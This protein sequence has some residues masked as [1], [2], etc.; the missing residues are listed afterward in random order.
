MTTEP[1]I[2]AEITEKATRAVHDIWCAL[3][4]QGLPCAHD[5][6]DGCD[7]VLQTNAVLEA[8]YAD[9]Q[10][11]ALR[12]EA[13]R[14]AAMDVNHGTGG[15]HQAGRDIIARIRARADELGGGTK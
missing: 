13:D 2:P 10:A 14:L 5:M 9:I 8:V 7:D 1:T 3:D 6:P 11:E 12:A 4:M 15:Y